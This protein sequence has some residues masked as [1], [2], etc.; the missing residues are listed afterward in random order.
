MTWLSASGTSAELE[1][2]Q[3]QDMWAFA[4]YLTPSGQHSTTKAPGVPSCTIPFPAPIL[5]G[6]VRI[7][8]TTVSYNWWPSL[9]QGVDFQ[10]IVFGYAADSLSIGDLPIEKQVTHQ[11]RTI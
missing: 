1:A 2:E 5:Q 4:R 8:S 7:N 9:D 3:R 11:R 6:G 10:A